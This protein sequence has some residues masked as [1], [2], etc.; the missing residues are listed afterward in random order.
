VVVPKGSLLI[1][2]L[3]LGAGPRASA[4]ELVEPA[5]A[6]PA[7]PVA[8]PP[9]KVD[10]IVPETPNPAPPVVVPPPRVDAVLPEPNK[11]ELPTPTI[12]NLPVKPKMNG[13]WSNGLTFES[14]DKNFR[15]MVGGV[16][17]FD[18][19]WYG[20]DPLLR[21]SVGRFN[22]LVDPNQSL[23][24]GMN[25]RRARLRMGGLAY[26]QIEF[27]AQ[28]E[29]ANSLD[30][31]QRTL[32]IPN[33]AGVANPLATNFDPADGIAF[34]EVYVGL[35]KLPVVGNVRVG[36]HRESLNFVTAT[37][38][39]YQIWMERGAMFEAFNGNNNFSNGI[40]VSRTYLDER[41][42]TLFGLFM[43]NNNNT[44]QI[45]TV[46]DGDYVYDGRLTWLA[47]D[48]QEE[49]LWVHFGA[50]Y[51]YRNL[52]QNN[53][54]LR[55]RPDVRV[56]TSFQVQSIIDTGNMFSPDALQIF[57]LEYAS[58]WGP[59][60]FAAEASAAYLTNAYTGGLPRPNGT[61][62]SG[63]VARGT[64]TASGAYVE[65]MRFLTN[66]HRGYVKER[67][68]YARVVPTR[69][70]KF[71]TDD[72]GVTAFDIGAWEVGVRYDYANLSHGGIDGGEFNGITGA[73]NW[74]LTS[75]ARVQWNLSWVRR[76]FAT[77]APAVG[78]TDGDFTAL[79]VRFNVDF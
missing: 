55:V 49:K 57:N 47:V 78:R 48:D 45:S 7:P 50:D 73:V 1:L 33:P 42:Y 53:V 71:K 20:V 59:W 15:M 39:N 26:D 35:V 67:P 37:A 77:Q 31:R 14:E 62:P 79:G 17:Q 3:L 23:Q 25:F 68:G 72:A 34:N 16:T 19:G 8:V 46:G 56:G 21:Q 52:Y 64:Y 41:V 74:Y 70:F 22:N 24:D 10:A 4:D 28:Y 29:F 76:T 66:D 11:L 40:T 32:G 30:L 75:N 51:S 6:K 13:T 54:R 65:L 63:V 60:T 69:R 2:A 44:R 58:A 38:D 27:Y 18:M 61:L 43:Q 36:R 5:S 9:P 12:P